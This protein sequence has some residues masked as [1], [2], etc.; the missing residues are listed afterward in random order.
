MLFVTV[1]AVVLLL[2]ACGFG[3]FAAYQ[4]CKAAGL[5]QEASE[6]RQKA[7]SIPEK[8]QDPIFWINLAR[9]HDDAA[10]RRRKSRNAAVGLAVI[11][12]AM[13]ILP[14]VVR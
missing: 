1:L 13:A 4:H 10:K 6:L 14:F 7:G 11:L 5:E 9:S 12:T 8:D 3:G 2:L